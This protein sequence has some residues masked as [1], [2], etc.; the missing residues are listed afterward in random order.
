[1]G[2]AENVKSLRQ[3]KHLSQ[4]QLAGLLNVGH[5]A[6]ADWEAGSA[7]PD[8]EKLLMLAEMFGTS[9]DRLV[10]RADEDEPEERIETGE[11]SIYSPHE[12]VLLDCSRVMVSKE[13]NLPEGS[14][15]YAIFAIDDDGEA[16]GGAQSTFLAWY[17]DLDG[18]KKDEA[19]ILEAL[20]KGED[21]YTLAHSVK[22]K[23]LGDLMV[24]VED[25]NEE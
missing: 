7:Y 16:L 20:E 21:S 3:K 22:T 24:I 11:I 4:E 23:W 18:A 5:E 25:D 12:K 8:F 2:F 17:G 19:A 13:F 9:L 6:V 15:R 1:M 10:G 14:P